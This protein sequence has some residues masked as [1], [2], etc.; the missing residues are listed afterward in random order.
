MTANYLTIAERVK[1]ARTL[2]GWTQ[3]QLAEAIGTKQANISH[4]EAGRQNPNADTQD[5]IFAALR[6]ASSKVGELLDTYDGVLGI[7]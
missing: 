2:A 5:R 4:I 6:N 1:S 7:Q 3:S